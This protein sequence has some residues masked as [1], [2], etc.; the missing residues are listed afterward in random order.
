MV[1]HDS[2]YDSCTCLL[3]HPNKRAQALLIHYRIVIE[4]KHV[5]RRRSS[6][7]GVINSNIVSSCEAQVLIV[8]D[9]D[10]PVRGRSPLERRFRCLLSPLE[11]DCGRVFGKD[12]SGTEILAGPSLDSFHRVVPGAIVN[13]HGEIV[14]VAESPDRFEAFQRILPAIPVEDA[15]RDPWWLVHAAGDFTGCVW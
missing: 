9:Q 1:C 14:R 10:Q 7:E 12:M 2:P 15:D 11:R 5:V 4:K 3:T 13:N 8:A 6:V